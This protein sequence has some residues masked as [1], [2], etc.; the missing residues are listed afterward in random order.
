MTS[1]QIHDALRDTWHK[2]RDVPP[3]WN[4]DDALAYFMLAAY[5]D[6][7]HADELLSTLRHAKQQIDAAIG[8]VEGACK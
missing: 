6:S 4:C 5:E 7:D 1:E 2:L 8:A 3:G